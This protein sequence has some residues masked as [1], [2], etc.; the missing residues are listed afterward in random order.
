MYSHLSMLQ[1]GY[2][3]LLLMN[4]GDEGA[5][6]FS[7]I[8]FKVEQSSDEDKLLQRI[9][10][11]DGDVIFPRNICKMLFSEKKMNEYKS[12]LNNEMFETVL[13]IPANRSS[14]MTIVSQVIN[15][16]FMVEIPKTV[17]LEELKS[18]IKLNEYLK[19]SIQAILV[20]QFVKIIESNKEDEKFNEIFKNNK[21]KMFFKKLVKNEK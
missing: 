16:H 15:N 13:S 14:V 9:E 10:C 21:E 2:E 12:E 20:E 1:E 4:T 3:Q 11:L 7:T 17:K 6:P 18:I 19:S 8:S 5:T